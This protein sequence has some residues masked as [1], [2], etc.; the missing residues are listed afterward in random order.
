M[1]PHILY[2]QHLLHTAVSL[3]IG[4]ESPYAS[5]RDIPLPDSGWLAS[6]VSDREL[7]F[8]ERVILLLAVMPYL[9]PQTLDIF[10]LRNKLMDRVYTEFGGKEG[11]S[12]TGFLPTGETAAFVLSLGDPEK[13]QSVASLLT[14]PTHWFRTAGILYLDGQGEGEPF[15]S[16][17]LQLTDDFSRKV[18]YGLTDHPAYS[19]DF[20][21]K[22]VTTALEWDE[23]V[24]PYD[25][26]ESINEIAAW[27]QHEREILGRWQLGRFVKQGYR[28]LFYGPPG[29]GKTLTATLLGK[30]YGLDVFRI[31]LSMVVSKYIG[32]TEKNLA[33]VFDR[34]EH[35]NWIL[36]F[37]EADA[38][39]GKRTQTSNA[40]DRHANQEVAYLLQRIEDFPGMIVLATNM[41]ENLDEAFLRRFQSVAYF[42]IPDQALRL[43][44]WQQMTPPEWLSAGQG[45][46]LLQLAS[47]T[48]LSGGSIVNVLQRCAI[49][50]FQS[51]K[52]TLDAAIL[53]QAITKEQLK[54]GKIV[55]YG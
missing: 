30:R 7:T 26:K 3:Y 46:D 54:E 17:R 25:L 40:N 52:Q 10:F 39:F 20:P 2:T 44:L 31:D 14:D 32:E 55:R 18:L 13:R 38:L 4:Q 35:R 15:L 9:S 33:R 28:C 29:T 50:L 12:H 49:K 45:H 47:E 53:R 48:E 24:L 23:L 27:L 51:G 6:L 21:A 8:E 41:K 34:A 37:D 1:T 11:V 16:G 36:F 22:R 42:P 19:A 5:I 43:R